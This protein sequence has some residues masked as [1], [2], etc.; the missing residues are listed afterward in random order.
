MRTAMAYRV[1]VPAFL[2]LLGSLVGC[3]MPS[4]E[5]ASMMADEQTEEF[6]NAVA[7]VDYKVKG[8]NILVGHHEFEVIPYIE[9]C[10]AD[11]SDHACGVRFEVSNG[12]KPDSRL[13]YA[14][15][16]NGGN[17]E[18]ALR[19]AV[20]GWWTEFGIPLLG[21]FGGSRSDFGESPFLFYPGVLAIRGAP[22]GGW[23][24]GTREMHQQITPVLRPL[25]D[26]RA[27]TK[28]ISIRLRIDRDGVTDMGSRI[29]GRLSPELV[30]AASALPWPKADT[31][32][33]V[34]QTFFVLHKG[35]E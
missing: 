3:Q 5:V 1:T 33:I 28:T 30:K 25:V 26:R 13:M 2:A 14:V 21:A 4:S 31:P 12:G 34:Y 22:P 6:K 19:H 32:Y 11:G 20:N 23:L 10:M 27:R 9:Q 17:R 7:G 8:T 24:D 35:E 29:D 15:V 18:A 16:G